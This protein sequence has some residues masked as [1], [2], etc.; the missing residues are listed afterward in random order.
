M[1]K[2]VSGL[3][4]TRLA[5]VFFALCVLPMFALALPPAAKASLMPAPSDVKVDHTIQIRDGGLMII[6]DEVKLSTKS[7]ESVELTNYTVGF[8]YDYQSNLDYA[9]ASEASDPSSMLKLE[10]DAGMGRIG[11]Y[12]VNVV[13]PHTV[14]ISDGASYEFSITFVFSNSIVPLV[15]QE[16]IMY[17]ASFPAYPS[18]TQSASEANLTIVFPLGLNYTISSFQKEG[19][20]FTTTIA[21]SNQYFNYLKNNL[22]EFSEQQGWLIISKA[23]SALELLEVIEVNRNIQFFGMEQLTVADSYRIMNKAENLER[24]NLR[25]PKN[26]F[27]ISALDEFGLIPTDKLTIEQENAHTRVAITFPRPYDK[28]KEAVFSVYY[29]LPWNNYVSAEDWSDFRVSLSLFE[30]FD[31]IIRKLTITIILPEGATLISSALSA[32]LDNIQNS[33]FTS[34]LSFVFWNASPFQNFS[35]DFTYARAVFW[36]SFRP[37]L[38]MGSLVTIIGAI[39]GAWRVAR[40]TAAPLPTAI[41]GIHAEELRSFT[42]LYDEKRR[43]QREIESLEAKARKGKIPRRR[44]KVRKMSIESRLTSISRDLKALEEKIR[45]A[46]PRYA[47]LMRQIEVS[48]TELEGV[49]ADINRTEV[50]Y[51]RGEISP[52]AYNKLLEDCYRRRDRA[53]T[54]IDGVLLRLREETI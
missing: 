20:N 18:L 40:P 21:G 52:A 50:R 46:G 48:E 36:E 5:I 41:I 44:Y 45:M 31:W 42:E 16:T 1:K 17:N 29:Q 13:F 9:F 27:D 39:V 53:K 33:A 37:T 30:N 11:F 22:S 23:A 43:F 34:S 8:P 2:W 7:G 38:W 12:G 47:G 10:L 3:K 14:T 6:N 26:A 51:R 19:V 24:I 25:L 35:F 54:A 28:N 32:G 4:R 15:E 49:E